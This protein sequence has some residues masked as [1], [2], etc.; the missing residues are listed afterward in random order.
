MQIIPLLS[1]GS[2][3]AE[4]YK[5]RALTK[6]DSRSVIL[7]PVLSRPS[8]TLNLYATYHQHST[9]ESPCLPFPMS[10][11]RQLRHRS[12]AIKFSP[13]AKLTPNCTYEIA[14]VY[15]LFCFCFCIF[16][17]HTEPPHQR[18]GFAVLQKVASLKAGML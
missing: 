6:S 5:P 10:S 7:T 3:K 14:P 18:G 8:S 16:W 12:S 1:P 11:L 9:S 17:G 13:P 4:T 15:V 2:L